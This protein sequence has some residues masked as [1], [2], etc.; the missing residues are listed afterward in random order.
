M[1]SDSESNQLL[2]VSTLKYDQQR[3]TF[4]K[5]VAEENRL[6]DELARINALDHS[7]RAQTAG[8]S[9]MKV[10]GADLMWQGWLTRSKTELNMQL[11][12]VLAIK[13][14]EQTKVRQAFGKVSALK[15]LFETE[16]TKRRKKSA[17]A[18][19]GQAI[20]QA[21]GQLSD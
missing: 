3:Q 20:E 18:L 10:I 12:C 17:Q 4:A 8:L 14:Q 13:A 9:E 16:E 15:E 19:M 5:V 6:R 2:I 7:G 1:R 21:L 11:A